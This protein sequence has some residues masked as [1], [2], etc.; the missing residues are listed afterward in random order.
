MIVN[1][2]LFQIESQFNRRI[3]VVE[4]GLSTVYTLGFNKRKT[5]EIFGSLNMD[6]NHIQAR[7]QHQNT[8]I[9]LEVCLCNLVC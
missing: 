7:I 5:Y 8:K 2:S 1:L 3:N 9:A 6:I 4:V